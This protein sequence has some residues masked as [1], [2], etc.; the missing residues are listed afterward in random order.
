MRE[1]NTII[2]SVTGVIMQ[3]FLIFISF[4]T[5]TV[6]IKYLGQYYLGINGLFSNILTILSLSELGIGSA[7]VFNMYKAVSEH[8]IYQLKSLLTFYA[9]VYH[10]LAGMIFIAGI[11]L[12]VFLPFL[13]KDNPY[14]I[15]YVRTV[16]LFVLI[17]TAVSYLGSY[18]SCIIFVNQK[19]YLIKICG[20]LTS[21]CCSLVQMIAIVV[22]RNY[23]VYLTVQ[24]VF[25]L[26][27][28]LVIFLLAK[29]MYP[30]IYVDK[31]C[32]LD[33]KTINVIKKKI[34]ALIIHKFSSTITNGTDN[35]ILS[36]FVGLIAVG[37]YSN[38]SL[39]ISNIQAVTEL[40]TNGVVASMGNL[41]AEKNADIVFEVYKKIQFICFYISYFCSVSLLVLLTPFIKIWVGEEYLFSRLIE[42]VLVLNFY[43]IGMRK[44]VLITRNAG[45]LYDKDKEAAIVKPVLNL[46]ISI[47]G[48][49]FYGI[50]GIFVG[51]L[52]S[53]IISDIIISPYKLY[54]YYFKKSF[55]GY[56]HMYIVYFLITV[57]TY[58]FCE[59][60]VGIFSIWITNS[61]LMFGVRIAICIGIPNFFFFFCFR[62]S[63]EF[64]YLIGLLRRLHDFTT[65]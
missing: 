31:K 26:I 18:R 29:K 20:G 17:N 25:T 27:N 11:F 16:F 14:D 15:N 1:R 55:R 53:S 48:A 65:L 22:F 34:S 61:I 6:F 49:A 47:V 7:I 32:K 28:N 42:I 60:F 12:T 38:Y 45:G 5:R 56:V 40:A 8:D 63:D 59:I 51:T 10:F 37:Q 13:I 41:I 39:I 9:K 24:I 54:N 46:L 44:A 64:Q 21:L 35:I 2:N 4:I 62:K 33:L 43:I 50:I 57:C 36:K 52:V 23:V 58:C 19:N 3:I 30:E